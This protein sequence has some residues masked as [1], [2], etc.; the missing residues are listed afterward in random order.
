MLTQSIALVMTPPDQSLIPTGDDLLVSSEY[1][2]HNVARITSL[3]SYSTFTDYTR[4][5]LHS[6][7]C[8]SR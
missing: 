8:L 7:C 6:S 3:Y 1:C 2:L 5:L 4:K